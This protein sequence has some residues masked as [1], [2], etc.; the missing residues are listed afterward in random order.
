VG[1][2]PL[3]AANTKSLD[4]YVIFHALARCRVS[5]ALR[6]DVEL[7]NLAD[8]RYQDLRGYGT[9]GRELLVGFRYAPR[10]NP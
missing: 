10:G 7:R 6:L 4:G 2:V 8:T 1:S 5:D 3:T 9:P